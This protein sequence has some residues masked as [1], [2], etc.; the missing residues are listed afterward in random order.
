MNMATRDATNNA[1]NAP[2]PTIEPVLE[3]RY[4]R[5]ELWSGFVTAVFGVSCLTMV[6]TFRLSLKLFAQ[7]SVPLKVSRSIRWS[8]TQH[9]VSA[10][11]GNKL[12]GPIL[13]NNSE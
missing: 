9:Q 3:Y 2:S 8:D 5:S 11:Q 1:N 6:P 7:H 4:F 10:V 12:D 13:P